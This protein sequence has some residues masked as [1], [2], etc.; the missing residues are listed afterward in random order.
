[1]RSRSQANAGTTSRICTAP[2]EASGSATPWS[3]DR[4][5]TPASWPGPIGRRTT[6]AA[7]EHA[8]PGGER[9]RGG[10]DHG[11]DD[12]TTVGRVGLPTRAERDALG[13]PDRARPV[14]RA[15]RPERAVTEEPRR[16]PVHGPAELRMDAGLQAAE[17]GR[18]AR[19]ADARTRG[20]AVDQPH[21]ALAP[22]EPRSR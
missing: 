11:D 1:M 21:A 12:S 19:G 16:D 14:R 7:D 17:V 5:S 13:L 4:T 8:Q 18:P 22:P 10:T 3:P 2:A 6:S 15:E 20:G 9:H